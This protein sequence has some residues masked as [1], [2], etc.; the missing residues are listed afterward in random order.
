M[1]ADWFSHHAGSLERWFYF[2]SVDEM[3]LMFCCNTR[4]PARSPCGQLWCSSLRRKRCQ[5]MTQ[6][7]VWYKNI[8]GN[9]PLCLESRQRKHYS[10][11]V[12]GR[13]TH[14][15]WHDPA[16]LPRGCKTVIVDR[17]RLLHCRQQ[18]AKH[19][20]GRRLFIVYFLFTCIE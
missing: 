5:Q 10:K 15:M 20:A 6:T 13:V 7:K 11:H 16:R 17:E 9:L 3:Y 19:Y 2:A 4:C 12:P 1:N 18:E 14:C 8:L